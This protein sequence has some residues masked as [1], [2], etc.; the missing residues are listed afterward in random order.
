MSKEYFVPWDVHAFIEVKFASQ[1]SILCR[2][3]RIYAVEGEFTSQKTIRGAMVISCF[4]F[5]TILLTG[6]EME[7]SGTF[8]ISFSLIT[9]GSFI[10]YLGTKN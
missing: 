1:T 2:E 7:V 6:R 5:N 8:I 3:R 4:L 10:L 9:L